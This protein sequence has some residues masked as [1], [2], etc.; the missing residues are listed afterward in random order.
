MLKL[1]TLVLFLIFPFAASAEATDT[2]SV[3]QSADIAVANRMVGAHNGCIFMALAALHVQG[4]LI[5]TDRLKMLDQF[6][7][8]FASTSDSLFL[9]LALADRVSTPSVIEIFN[10][11]AN[12]QYA[13]YASQLDFINKSTQE[14]AKP[15]S[16]PTPR[17]D[18]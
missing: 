4:V 6:C 18:I 7:R 12:A 8:R 5:S 14:S 16:K 13:A 10:S 2:I 3:D 1:F 17:T 15:E 9:P 11:A